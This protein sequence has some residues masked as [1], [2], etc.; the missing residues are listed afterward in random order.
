MSAINGNLRNDSGMISRLLILL[1]VEPRARRAAR[2]CGLRA[3][4]VRTAAVALLL[5]LVIALCTWPR[6][7]AQTSPSPGLDP[8]VLL[9]PPTDT[10]PTYNGDYTGRRYS[11]LDQINQENIESLTL[12]WVF[13][14]RGLN[15]KSTPLEVSGI[16]Y[17]SSPDNVWAVDA[18]LGREIWHYE[19]KTEGGKIGHRGVAMWK[20]YLYFETGDAH[21][22]SLNAK[23]G[24]ERW[25][26]ELADAKLGYFATMAPLVIRGQ[27][28]IRL[29]TQDVVDECGKI[30]PRPEFEEHTHSVRV[31]VP[32]GFLK[33][34]RPAPV[35]NHEIS[36]FFDAGWIKSRSG[37]GINRERRTVHRRGIQ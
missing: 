10:W 23:D 8:A 37:T 21:L 16:L 20:D 25:T 5:H 11:T 1:A 19:T 34:H 7:G 2:F 22:V 31:H 6:A 3:V 13:S 9:N 27:R 4:A 36:N 17:F 35:V 26:I 15:L 18:R 29:P 24:K 14:T 33:S 32:D 12:A 30:A 28:Q